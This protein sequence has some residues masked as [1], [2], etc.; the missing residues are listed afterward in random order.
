MILYM[1][2]TLIIVWDSYILILQMWSP[3]NW[4][5]AFKIESNLYEWFLKISF[6]IFKMVNYFVRCLTG[7]SDWWLLTARQSIDAF[8]KYWIAFSNVFEL[9]NWLWRCAYIFLFSNSRNHTQIWVEQNEYGMKWENIN[10][11]KTTESWWLKKFL[12]HKNSDIIQWKR[13]KT[14]IMKINRKKQQKQ[15]SNLIAETP[16]SRDSR[17]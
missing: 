15:S 4:I 8:S 3:P 14:K 13:K 1:S 7:K 17:Q 9:H 12:G 16:S 6:P 2:A 11:K 5:D 10:G